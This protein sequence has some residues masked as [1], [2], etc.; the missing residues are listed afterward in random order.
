MEETFSLKRKEKER[1]VKR[2]RSRE[3]KLFR[4]R[5]YKED[6]EEREV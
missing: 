3:K 4:D 6:K 2:E 1:K 5:A